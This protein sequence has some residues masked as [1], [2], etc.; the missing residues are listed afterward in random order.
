MGVFARILIG[1]SSE[2][3]LR[4][5]YLDPMFYVA[6]YAYMKPCVK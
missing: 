5:F 3:F 2:N 1:Y 6:K 4:I